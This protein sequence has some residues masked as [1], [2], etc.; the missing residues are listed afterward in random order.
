MNTCFCIEDNHGVEPCR[1]IA[2]YVQRHYKKREE[3]NE[4]ISVWRTEIENTLVRIVIKS[5]QYVG[6]TFTAF[7]F[8]ACWLIKDRDKFIAGVIPQSPHPFK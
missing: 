2:D 1:G 6:Q 5:L 4:G 3:T 8:F 7:F